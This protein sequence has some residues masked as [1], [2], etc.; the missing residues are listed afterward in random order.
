MIKATLDNYIR[1]PEGVIY[2]N[3]LGEAVL[4]NLNSGVYFGLNEMGTAMWNALLTHGQVRPA[5][6]ALLLEFEAAEY[7]LR[8]DLLQLL[9]TLVD[10]G[11]LE[12]DAPA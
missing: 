10:H 1:V 6:Q 12:L 8:Q 2:Q 11:L 9:D 4:L 7:I 3:T 5:Y